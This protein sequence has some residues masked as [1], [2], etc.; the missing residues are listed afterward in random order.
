MPALLLAPLQK[1]L[2]GVSGVLSTHVTSSPLGLSG[3]PPPLHR[4]V[5]AAPDPQ[6]QLTLK[7]TH[8]RSPVKLEDVHAP[9]LPQ[10]ASCRHGSQLLPVPVHCPKRCAQVACP[11]SASHT[12]Q[13]AALPQG[14]EGC[15]GSH[16]SVQIFVPL[17][18]L[19]QTWFGT[20]RQSASVWHVLQNSRKRQ[21]FRVTP[22]RSH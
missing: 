13:L 15:F 5:F 16:G 8:Q 20:P 21:A 6:L 12:P 4:P 1:P 7:S 17:L 3:Q 14:Q 22:R 19:A 9:L 11:S 18:S 2:F 10:S